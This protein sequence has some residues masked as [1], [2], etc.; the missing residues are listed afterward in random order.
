[1]I[2]KLRI[3]FRDYRSRDTTVTSIYSLSL[4]L[5]EIFSEF[6]LERALCCELGS[7]CSLYCTYHL[8]WS[9]YCVT[10]QESCGGNPPPYNDQVFPVCRELLRLTCVML[11]ELGSNNFKERCGVTRLTGSSDPSEFFHVNIFSPTVSK[12]KISILF[13]LISDLTDFGRRC[14]HWLKASPDVRTSK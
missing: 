7:K 9:F 1:M 3:I 4:R 10:R 12:K 6:Y 14:V 2:I 13:N 5:N 8:L 11:T